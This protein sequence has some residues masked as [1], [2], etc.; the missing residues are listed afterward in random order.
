MS[1][2]EYLKRRIYAP[3]GMVDSCNHEPAADPERMSA[4]FRRK[5]DGWRISWRPGDPPKVP[6]P[7]ASGGMISTAGDYAVFCQMFL[8]GGVRGDKRLLSE[9]HVRE[10]TTPQNRAVFS[11]AERADP[12]HRFY[13]LGWAV[14]GRIFSHGGSD[15]T[16]AWVDPERAVVGLVFTQSTGSVNPRAQFMRAVAAACKDDR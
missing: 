10:A 5:E 13:G 3:L 11:E 7:R 14:R 12:D 6:F 8:D 4:L 16:F 9:T 2:S 15:G 1:L